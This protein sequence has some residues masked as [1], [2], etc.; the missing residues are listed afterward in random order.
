MAFKNKYG[1]PSGSRKFDGVDDRIS[2]PTKTNYKQLGDITV[3]YWLKLNSSATLGVII[4]LENGSSENEADNSIYWNSLTGV[5]NSWDITYI[6]EYG[7]GLNELNTFLT[8][9]TND[10]WYHIAFVRDA[11]A[12]TVICYKSGIAVNTFNYTNQ[13][14]TTSSTVPLY[15]SD[16]V[17]STFP[18]TNTLSE[19]AMWSSKLSPSVILDLAKGSS[20]LKFPQNLEWHP[21]LNGHSSIELDH[22]PYRNHGVVTGALPAQGPP[23]INHKFLGRQFFAFGDT[24]G[25]VANLKRSFVPMVIG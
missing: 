25:P 20:P 2:F 21:R 4:T 13:A 10:K 16:R 12:K 7:S 24:A 19:M 6:H 14:T 15:L 11:T 5:S 23:Q 8:N 1:P 17:D 9:I 18:S 3:S 22:S